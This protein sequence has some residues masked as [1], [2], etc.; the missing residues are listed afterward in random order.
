MKYGLIVL[1]VIV[2]VAGLLNHYA[3]KANPI[4]HTSTILIAVGAVIAVVGLA[5]TFMGSKSAS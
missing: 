2:A 5:M 1:G 3:I 4:A